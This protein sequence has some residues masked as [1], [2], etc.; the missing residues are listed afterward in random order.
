MVMSKKTDGTKTYLLTLQ[1]GDLRKVTVPTAWKMTFGLT[2]PYAAKGAGYNHGLALRFYE[3]SEKN[4]RAVFTD[5]TAVRDESIAILEKRTETQRKVVTRHTPQGAK[6]VVVEA[7]V[8]EWLNPD[9]EGEQAI[10]PFAQ[11]LKP[12]MLQLQGNTDPLAF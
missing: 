3:G 6:D 9:D 11:Q 2:A 1:N 8:T 5:V 7:R 12:D 10:N 4:L